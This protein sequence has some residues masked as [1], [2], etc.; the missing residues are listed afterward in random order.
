MTIM[1]GATKRNLDIRFLHLIRWCSAGSPPS[2]L[3]SDPWAVGVPPTSP[4]TE[5]SVCYSYGSRC[6][7]VRPLADQCLLALRIEDVELVHGYGERDVVADADLLVGRQQRDDL[8]PLGLRVDELLAAEVLDDV[9][10]GRESDRVCRPGRLPARCAPAGSRS[11]RW[12]HPVASPPPG[13]ARRS[14]QLCAAQDQVL[15]LGVAVAKFM[16]GEPMN[17]ATKTFTGWS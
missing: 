3:R 9:D 4:G 8:V 12:R 14:A 15:A 5:G 7:C 11:A 13:P 16:A 1:N 10:L 2:P 17:P 6:D